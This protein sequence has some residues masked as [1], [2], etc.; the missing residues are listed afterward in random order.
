MPRAAQVRQELHFRF[1]TDRVIGTVDRDAGLIELRQQSFDRNLED[2]GELGDRY[3]SHVRRPPGQRP[4][5]NFLGDQAGRQRIEPAPLE[6]GVERGRIV[7]NGLDVEHGKALVAR[8]SA[9]ALS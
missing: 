6:T 1:V 9:L 7:A 2:F 3:I 8:K 5:T 4:R